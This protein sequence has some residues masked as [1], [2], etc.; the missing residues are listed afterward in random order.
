MDEAVLEKWK[1]SLPIL[2]KF[3]LFKKHGLGEQFKEKVI[4][5]AAFQYRTLLEKETAKTINVFP[6][7]YRDIEQYIIETSSH[8][9]DADSMV[10]WNRILYE[11]EELRQ[12]TKFHLEMKR[13]FYKTYLSEIN[14]RLEQVFPLL[15]NAKPDWG[16]IREVEE[17]LSEA[18]ING[19]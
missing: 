19:R 15:E 13:D 12:K 11:D 18:H 16:K 2:D 7:Y 8:L 3:S 17:K 14:G 1:H 6:Q 5:V 4:R 10:K 9:S